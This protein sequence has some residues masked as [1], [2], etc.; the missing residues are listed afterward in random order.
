MSSTIKKSS[1]ENTVQLFHRY[2]WLVDTINSAK[3]ISYEEINNH[4]LRSSLNSKHEDLPKKTFS[5]HK[6]A[7]EEMFNIEIKC[8]RSNG[9]K[10]YIEDNIEERQKGIRRWLLNSL[11]VNNLLLESK[12]LYE[13]VLFED[14]PSG[15]HYMPEIVS[16]MKNNLAIE[17]CYQSFYQSQPYT[18]QVNPYCLKIFHQRWYLVA[19]NELFSEVRTYAL[20]RIRKV[21]ATDHKFKIQK[22]F[23]AELYFKDC[24][25]IIHN[26]KSEQ[27]DIKVSNRENKHL[28]L[29]SLPL[30]HS[31]TIIDET[32]D[33]TLFRYEVMPTY[34][35]IQELLSHAPE[36]EVISPAHLRETIK[37]KSEKLLQKHS[38]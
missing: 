4:W 15:Q 16:C 8:S 7:V 36:I 3:E 32:H 6:A 30:H 13:R 38:E 24:F 14:I 22:N 20:D 34:D 29:K 25:G 10:Y 11:S 26:E 2:V 28:Y 5:N 35:F 1:K 12:E 33:Y 18:F 27:I 19:Y 31:Q 17:I 21:E 9:C 23:D 37:E